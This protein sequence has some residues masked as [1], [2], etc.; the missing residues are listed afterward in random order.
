VNLSIVIPVFRNESTIARALTSIEHSVAGVGHPS[1]LNVVV[2]IDGIVDGSLDIV[3]SWQTSTK[4]SNHVIIQDNAGIAAARNVA[5]RNATTEWITF[6]DADDEMTTVRLSFV[7]DR[8]RSGTVFIG[9]QDLVIAEG[10]RL[11]NSAPSSSNTASSPTFHFTSMLIERTVLDSLGGF[12]ESLRLSDDWDLA[13][14]LKEIGVPIEYVEE[15]FVRR[16]I[17]GQN[18]SYDEATVSREYLRTIRDHIRRSRS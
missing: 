16:H 9:Q 1:T 10:L 18:A 8:L 3:R 2:V 7:Q 6:L 12:D 13:I 17:H 14:R 15:F 4:L 11:P 5:W